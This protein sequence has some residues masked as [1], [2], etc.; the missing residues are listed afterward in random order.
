MTELDET[1]DPARTSWVESANGHADFPIQNLPFGVFS[2]AGSDDLRTGVAIGDEILDLREAGRAGLLSGEA[3]GAAELASNGTLN[4]LMAAV[5]GYEQAAGYAIPVDDSF[6]RVLEELRKIVVRI[7]E[8]ESQFE[9]AKSQLAQKAKVETTAVT[10]PTP[11]PDRVPITEVMK[12]PTSQATR[13]TL[14]K[15]YVAELRL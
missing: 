9:L 7:F 10:V 5:A 1:H 13:R 6:R 15:R 12:K 2:P 11:D 14:Y 8:R 3:S 4:R